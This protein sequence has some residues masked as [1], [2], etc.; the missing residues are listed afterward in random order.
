MFTFGD[1]RNIAVQIE[2]NGEDTYRKTS[3]AVD[4]PELREL[5]V[6]MA[7]E[8]RRHA[9]WFS[10][11]R[12]EK[13]LT[14]EQRE[15]ENV[16]RSLLQDMLKGSTFLLDPDRLRDSAT[17]K[18]L[19]EQ[20]I[21]FEEDTV[22]FYEFLQGFLEDEEAVEQLQKIIVEERNHAR[23]LELMASPLGCSG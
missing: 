19:L 9:Q 21:A 20:S 5:L 11:L 15:L 14:E 23:Q 17:L 7:D 2:R 10:S 6:W 4:D 18:E 22:L 8:E 13:V 12:S 1:I 3:E 16:G